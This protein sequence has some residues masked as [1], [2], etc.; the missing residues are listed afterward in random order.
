MTIEQYNKWI[1]NILPDA[2]LYDFTDK[3]HNVDIHIMYMLARTQ[4]MF[5]WAG[6]PD[7]I[8][9]RVLELYLQIN[10]NCA[11]YEHD[12]ELYI[13]CGGLGGEPDAY[14]RPTIYTIAN[15]ALKI[16]KNLRINED[17]IVMINDSLLIGMMPLFSRYATGLVENELSINI[18]SINSRI[19]DV[20]S[21]ADDRTKMS[22]EQYLA[23]VAAGKLGVI[24][25]AQFFD[26]IKSQPYGTTGHRT[27]TDLIELEQYLKASW[28]NEIG[29]NANYNMK[30]ESINSKES[31]LNNDA[32]LPLVDD[33]L[34][35]RQIA[36]DRVN[37][38]YGTTISVKLASSWEDNIEEIELEHDKLESEGGESDEGTGTDGTDSGTPD[39]NADGISD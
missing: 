29:L 9:A 16:S 18:A 19:I 4:S 25:E 5:E 20:L 15:P 26:G 28:Y 22:A 3:E 24:G 27:I 7:T 31:Q 21:A 6:L 37:E 23:D 34:K 17:C 35:C 32:L 13:F 33:M 38:M 12:G 8:P 2:D 39:D 10:G 36:A 30:R 1:R 11:F 14:Y